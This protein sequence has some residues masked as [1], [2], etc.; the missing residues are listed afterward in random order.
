MQQDP[1]DEFHLVEVVR[2]PS[3]AT[4]SGATRCEI[5]VA[6]WLSH[7]FLLPP[8]KFSLNFV[9]DKATKKPE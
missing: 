8:T 4:V 1:L 6:L 5:T 2:L 3:A 9:L 7:L